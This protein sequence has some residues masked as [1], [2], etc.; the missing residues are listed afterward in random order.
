MH[1]AR[2]GTLEPACLFD[3]VALTLVEQRAPRR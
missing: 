2:A 3:S 1:R